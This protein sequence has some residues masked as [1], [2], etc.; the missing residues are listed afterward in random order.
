MNEYEYT[1]SN[2]KANKHQVKNNFLKRPIKHT[3]GC[4][5]KNNVAVEIM[6]MKW[7][8]QNTEANYIGEKKIPK[9]SFEL[10]LLFN[11]HRHTACVYVF[12]FCVCL[13]LVLLLR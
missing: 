5:K 12:D 11:V 8:T 2:A 7:K 4:K 13:L 9:K 6:Q 1:P 10:R 3:N